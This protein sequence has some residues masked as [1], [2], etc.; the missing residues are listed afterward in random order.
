MEGQYD[1]LLGD[2]VHY[3]LVPGWEGAGTVVATGGGMSTWGMV[4]RRVAFSK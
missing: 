3:P 1:A 4:G 2:K